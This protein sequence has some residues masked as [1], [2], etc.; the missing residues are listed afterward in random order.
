MKINVF[1]SGVIIAISLSIQAQN[2]KTPVLITLKN[3]ETIDA[4]HFGSL[5]CGTNAYAE[6]Y[7]LIRGKYMGNV[8]EIKNYSDIEKITLQ[9]YKRP[10][11]ASV[12]NEK[13]KVT[14]FKKNGTSYKMDDAE[15]ALSCYSVGDKY[16]EIIVQ[17]LNPVSNQTVDHKI[18]TRSIQSIVFK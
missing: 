2:P 10:A 7:I 17:I 1:I 6:T 13:G 12:G 14:I 15:L 8:T 16:N 11:E 3:G 4:L 9:G 5:K 18:E